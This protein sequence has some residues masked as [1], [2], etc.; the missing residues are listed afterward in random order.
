MKTS[1]HRLL[2]SGAAGLI[3]SGF[4]MFAVRVFIGHE[5]ASAKPQIILLS[6]GVIGLILL[7]TSWMR[8]RATRSD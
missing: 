2:Q 4:V 3:G 1:T 5:S 8:L 7:I 6:S